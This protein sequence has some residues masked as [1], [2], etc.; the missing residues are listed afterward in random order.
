MV[1]VGIVCVVGV[2]IDV[3]VIGGVGVYGVARG[4]VGC[5]YVVVVW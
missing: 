3:D 2:V 4:C 5:V 1:V